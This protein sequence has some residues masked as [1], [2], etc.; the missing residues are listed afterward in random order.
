MEIKKYI[1]YLFFLYIKFTQSF[2]VISLQ[3]FYFSNSALNNNIS[4]IFYNLR[5]TYSYTYIKIGDPEY[6]IKTTFSLS[7]PHFSMTSNYESIE[8]KNLFNYYN[9]E[10]SSTFINV[11]CLNQYYVQT[12]NDIAAKEKFK[13]NAYNI[14]DNKHK[15]II[16]NDLD[17][18]LGVRNEYQKKENLSEIYFLTIGL[19][20]FSSSKY[21]QKQ[22]LTFIPLLKHKNII[23][24]YNWFLY[25]EKINRNNDELYN[26]DDLINSKQTLLIGDFPHKYKSKEFY[27]EQLFPVYSNHFLWI[28]EFKTVYFYRN[29]T[30]YN[31][32]FKQDIYLNKAQLNFNDIFIFAPSLYITMIK[33]NY[34][35]NYISRNVYHHYIDSQIESFYCDKSDNFTINDL[36]N[37][38]TLYFEHNELNYTFELTYKDLFVEKDNKYIFMIVSEMGDVD[39]WFFGKIFFRKYQLVFNQDS[40]TIGFY[41]LNLEIEINNEENKTKTIFI[42]ESTNFIYIISIIIVSIILFIGLGFIIGNYIKKYKKKKRANELDDD[43]EYISGNKND[44]NIN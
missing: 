44:N 20:L 7:S 19:Q 39:D 25:Y 18:V 3:I 17:F 2:D 8:E 13:I 21:T 5:N 35:N 12:K 31:N 38:P 10:R 34:F 29:D 9:I 24:N 36:K 30:K 14:E 41:N 15:E 22:Q 40:K 28:L 16:I 27:K 4:S 32:Y 23:E 11:S 26:L 6:S 43:Y 33:N 37:F 1:I 42:N